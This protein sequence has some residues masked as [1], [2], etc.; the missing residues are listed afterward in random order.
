MALVEGET[1]SSR[2]HR[3]GRIDE[4]SEAIALVLRVAD[5]LAAVHAAHIVHRDLKPGNILLDRSGE[6]YLTDFGLAHVADSNDL[7]AFGQLLGTPAYMA[8]EQAAPERGP[9]SPASDQYSLAVVLYQMLTGRLPFEGSVAS[10]IFQIATQPVPPLSRFRPDIDSALEAVCLK[11]LSKEPGA[12]FGSMRD[13]AAGLVACLQHPAGRRDAPS[14]GSPA[15]VLSPQGPAPSSGRTAPVNAVARL[16]LAARYFL[17]KRTVEGVRNGIAT[18]HQILD[19]DPTFA[20]G[21]ATLASAYHLLSVRGH[22]SPTT[23]APKARSAALRAIE[24]DGSLGEAHAALAAIFMEYEWDLLRA[25]RTFRA[26]LE[27]NP[28]QAFVHHLYGKCLACLGRFDE[29]IAELRRAEELDP[30]SLTFSV[31]VGRYGYI[32]ARRYDEAVQ[33]FRKILQ[34]DPDF[35]PAHR[36]LGWAWVFQGDHRAALTEFEIAQRLD[37][38]SAMLVGQGYTF[39]VA[40]QRAKALEVLAT[41]TEL[42]QQRYLSPDDF[43]ILAIGLGDVDQAFPWMAKAVEDRS[44]WFCKFGVD[45]VLDPLRSDPR[46]RELL[47]LVN[48]A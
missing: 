33:Q 45:P 30:I 44:E 16:Y 21:W 29:A 39:A 25:E 32:F 12:R 34:T 13:F 19:L 47:R 20:P 3:Q 35:A 26:A 28:R 48:G 7:T 4:P 37:D 40:G 5:A 38:D 46:F 6:P 8:P 17:E 43:G 9:V 27:L 2:L 31:A 42:A 41:L 23:T 18:C 24:L 14:Q 11:A 10:L 1:L 22:V 36:F 15:P